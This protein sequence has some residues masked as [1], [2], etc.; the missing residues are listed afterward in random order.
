[1]AEIIEKPSDFHR[2]DRLVLIGGPSCVGKSFL[3][4]KIKQDDCPDL[5][6][7]I[8]IEDPSLWSYLGAGNLACM[9]RSMN[10]LIVH[11]DICRFSSK[12]NIPPLQKLLR[13]SDHITAL[14]LCI[15]SRILTRRVTLRLCKRF[16]SLWLPS[17][18]YLLQLR[19]LIYLYRKRKAFKLG[20]LAPD[21]YETWFD[22]LEDFSVESHWLLDSRS[23]ID[24]ARPAGTDKIEM[25]GNVKE[26]LDG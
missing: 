11:Y 20:T 24:L 15:P 8:G 17:S 21:L 10:S 26:M 4:N 25:L 5:C 18:P 23:T 2:I 14:T 19:R 3:I 7:Q 22:V 9:P 1:M 16:I 6:K 12:E 13:R